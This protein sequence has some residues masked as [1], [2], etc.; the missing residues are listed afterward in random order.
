MALVI[1]IIVGACIGGFGTLF[2]NMSPETPVVFLKVYS[3]P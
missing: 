1:T 3:C 2:K